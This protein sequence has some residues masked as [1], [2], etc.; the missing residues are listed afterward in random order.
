MP[1]EHER[2]LGGWHAEWE[3]LPELFLLA[4]GSLGRGIEAI[5]GLKVSTERMR[6]NLDITRGLV[7]AEAVMMALAPHV[8]RDQAYRL[9]EEASGT[10]RR[11][12]RN[13][14][15]VLSQ[16]STIAEYLSPSALETIFD[17]SSQTA[18]SK[19]LVD[20]L[21]ASRHRCQEAP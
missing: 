5:A 15:E 2:G 20:R 1:Q 3:T 10:A 21:L 17:H 18:L 11:D 16:D 7:D 6:D 8:G 4:S 19:R 14:R 12:N 9:V 13:L